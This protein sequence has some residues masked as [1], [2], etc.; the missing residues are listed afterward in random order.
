MQ[1]SQTFME[2][3]IYKIGVISMHGLLLLQKIREKQ[4][5]W[6]YSNCKLIL[7]R[8]IISLLSKEGNH[9]TA[10]VPQFVSLSV[11]QSV[12]PSSDLWRD[13][14]MDQYEFQVCHFLLC[15]DDA[16]HFVFSKFSKNRP[17]I[18]W[19]TEND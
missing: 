3:E 2:I 19:N 13:G 4:K 1:I 5:L 8:F 18:F 14:W 10:D 16:Y 7:N 9:K 17:A 6:E 15:E 12:R 11:C